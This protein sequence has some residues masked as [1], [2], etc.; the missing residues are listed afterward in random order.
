MGALRLDI[1]YKTQEKKMKKY[2]VILMAVVLLVSFASCSKT[3]DAAPAATSQLKRSNY[4]ITVLTGP[5]S[6]I[7]YPIGGAFNSY[8]SQIGYR[9]SATATGATAENIT[10]AAGVITV[11]FDATA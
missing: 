1:H 6:G 9:S 11:K 8:L 3:S 10:Y 7:Y 4:F 2:L 5:T